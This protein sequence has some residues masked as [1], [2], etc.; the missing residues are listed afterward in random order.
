MIRIKYIWILIYSDFINNVVSA[1]FF[2]DEVAIG[3]SSLSRGIL[4][5]QRIFQQK[6]R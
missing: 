1:Y 4:G 6:G 5:S 3:Y 2:V